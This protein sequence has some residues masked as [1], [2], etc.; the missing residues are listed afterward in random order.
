MVQFQGVSIEWIQKENTIIYFSQRR[1][2]GPQHM[3]SASCWSSWKPNKLK[4]CCLLQL[5][6]SHSRLRGIRGCVPFGVKSILCWFPF[7]VQSVRVESLS[8]L[9]LFYIESHSEFSPFRVESIQGWGHSGLGPFGVESLRGWVPSGL[10][11]F[12]VESIWGS[13]PFEVESIR[14][15]VLF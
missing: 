3:S 9:S 8:V 1:L 11:P 14:T 4:N 12:R 5:K 7:W 15:K 10:S 2:S 13:V 6:L